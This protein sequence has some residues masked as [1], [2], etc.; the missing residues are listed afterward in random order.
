MKKKLSGKQVK[1]VI[2]IILYLIAA[3]MIYPEPISS[4]AEMVTA[5]LTPRILRKEWQ[6]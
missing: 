6:A 3:K 2:G 1:T 4:D 5:C